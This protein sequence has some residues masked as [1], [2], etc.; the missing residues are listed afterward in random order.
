MFDAS[1]STHQHICVFKVVSPV[2]PDLPLTSNVPNIQFKTLRLDALNVESLEKT[3]KTGP[4]N[5]HI[6]AV[7]CLFTPKT[8][9]V[10]M[11]LS[12]IPVWG[13]CG[14]C[15]QMPAVLTGWSSR[16]CPDP[17][18]VS[19]PPGLVCSLAYAGWTAIPASVSKNC[20]VGGVTL[21]GGQGEHCCS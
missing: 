20:R 1:S 12:S 11:K 17:A 15:P 7:L 3:Q 4:K 13:W 18:A 14:W 8:G 21:P 16:R 10:C 2:R 5:S 6:P 9:G 19:L